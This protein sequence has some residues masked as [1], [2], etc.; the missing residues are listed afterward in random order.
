MRDKKSNKANNAN[1]SKVR[2]RP[3]PFVNADDVYLTKNKIAGTKTTTTSAKRGYT[4]K[5]QTKYY[6]RNQSNMRRLKKAKGDTV[7]I[8][9]TG[10][11]Y[12]RI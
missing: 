5:T 1:T 2:P 9:R 10:N 7:R 4:K 8:G 11:N 6:E 12:G 3:D